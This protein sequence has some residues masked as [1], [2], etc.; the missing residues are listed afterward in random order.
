MNLC[1]SS[2]VKKTLMNGLIELYYIIFS[3]FISS[4][5]QGDIN[6]PVDQGPENTDVSCSRILTTNSLLNFNWILI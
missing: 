1:S 5:L 3:I 4:I 6:P 2:K